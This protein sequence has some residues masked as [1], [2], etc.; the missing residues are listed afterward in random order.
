MNFSAPPI[1]D[2][3]LLRKLLEVARMLAGPYELTEMLGRIVDAG[4]T[5]LNADRGTVFLYDAATRE[6]YV[7]IGTGIDELRFSID[8]GIAGECARTRAII[9][10]PDCY[11]DPRFN[12]EIDRKTGYR[13]QTLLAAPLIGLDGQLV[14]VMQLLNSGNGRFSAADEVLAETFASHAAVAI[15]R[16]LLLEERLIRLKLERD[17]EVARQIQQAV[18]PQ[19]LPA[20]K[21]YDLAAFGRPAEQTGGDIYDLA[22]IPIDDETDAC[23]RMLVMLADATGHG[24]GPALSVT[25]VRSMIRLAA[26]LG[27][28]LDEVITQVNRQL[29]ADLAPNRFVT[30]FVG[31]L[32]GTTHELTYQAAGQGPLLQV[33]G[34][35]GE[36]AFL[37]ASTMPMGIVADLPLDPPEPMRLTAGDLVVLLTDGFYEYQN[38]AGDQFGRDRVAKVIAENRHRQ[39][40]EILDALLQALDQF[41][42][43]AP[44]ADDLTAIIIKREF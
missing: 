24:I 17:L 36:C 28:P 20:M 11:A 43:G 39:A 12:Q 30:A 22:G 21:G 34:C 41:A 31:V 9:N 27:V 44:Q 18:L 13:T 42:A 5:V 14:G 32:D 40:K 8:K 33:C 2:N 1:T 4:R 37:N 6:L 15:Q 38:A 25:Q 19:K 23:Q 26:R 10:V 29:A 3:R 7:K 35:T 16:S